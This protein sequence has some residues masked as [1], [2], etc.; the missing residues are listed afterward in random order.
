MISDKSK[1][2]TDL[3]E[4]YYSDRTYSARLSAEPYINGWNEPGSLPDILD[5]PASRL[6]HDAQMSLE[7]L[8]GAD[9]ANVFQ[10]EWIDFKRKLIAYREIQDIFPMQLHIKS[11]PMTAMRLWYFYFEAD[12]LMKDSLL[13]GLHFSGAS[14]VAI[15]RPF[16]E[17][18]ILQLY[19]YRVTV[20]SGTLKRLEEYHESERM[21]GWHSALKASMPNNTFCK[22]IRKRMQVHLNDLS[23]SA[24]HPYSHKLSPRNHS[25]S[26][27]VPHMAGVAF[28]RV[29]RLVLEAVLWA[30][31]VNFPM[32]FKPSD[33]YKKFGCNRPMGRFAD[34]VCT[35]AVKYALD[36][37]DFEIFSNYAELDEES[38]SAIEWAKNKDD[39]T[40]QELKESCDSDF[41]GSEDEMYPAAY[42]MATAKA[43]SLRS[44]L[45][46]DIEGLKS[47]H[48]RKAENL[49]DINIHDFHR[50]RKV[51]KEM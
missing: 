28:W 43:R 20:Q 27:G 1:F 45:S 40:L 29:N 48:R 10:D 25:Y 49:P 26:P 6:S 2:S 4:D 32:L 12:Y 30:Y 11:N 15:L 21:P 16:L 22:P 38:N 7:F 36:P 33:V 8:E 31:Y 47:S 13:A 35:G 5:I 17:F 23:N 51:Y 39:L 14:S 24:S 46:L 34:D 50:W 44:V 18:S 41:T 3:I 19:F 37:T 42:L 9:D